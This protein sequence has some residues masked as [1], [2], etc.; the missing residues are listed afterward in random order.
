M[1]DHFRLFRSNKSYRF[2]NKTLILGAF[3]LLTASFAISAEGD[4]P[5]KPADP[6]ARA[7]M[8]LEKLDTDK[9]GTL[10][11]EE[12]AAGPIAEREKE[13]PGSTDKA[14]TARDTN[15]DGQLDLAELSVVPEGKGKPGP[16]K[17]K[18]AGDAPAAPAA[19]AEKP[20][21]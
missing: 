4:K 14:F 17:P 11:K 20:A 7:K 15:K 16:G 12:F 13:K 6:A 1:E 2:M 9:N 3:A 21:A 18:P 19:P 5:K 8:M 10:S